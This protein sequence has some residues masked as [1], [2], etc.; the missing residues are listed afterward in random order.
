V[1]RIGECFITYLKWSLWVIGGLVVLGAIIN[2][3]SGSIPWET[4]FQRPEIILAT[5]VFLYF[6]VRGTLYLK[7]KL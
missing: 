2:L 5:V 3:I 4:A 1:Y 7:K 6:V